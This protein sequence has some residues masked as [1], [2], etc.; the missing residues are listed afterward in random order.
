MT[1]RFEDPR[2]ALAHGGMVVFERGWL[3]SNGVLFP[4][5]PRDDAALVD[6]GYVAHQAQTEALVRHALG[7]DAP[8][9]RLI[10]THLHSDHCGGNARLQ[11]AFACRTW[12]PT[13]EFDRAQRWDT[14]HLTYEATGQRCPRF[15]VHDSLEPGEHVELG[16]RPWE[17]I[18]SPGHDPESV[19]LY[20]REL[21][22]VISADALWENGFGVVFPELEGVGAFDAV[23]STLDRLADLA[24]DWVIPGHGRVFGGACAAIDRARRRLDSFRSDPQKHA[25]HAAKVLVKFHLLEVRA[26]RSTALREWAGSV[27]YLRLMRDLYF[28]Q[29]LFAAWFETVLSDL[30]RS[31]AIRRDIEYVYDA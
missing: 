30:L 28:S 5:G 24:I 6:S 17:I 16:G 2:E 7:G 10:N 19:V 3:S 14:E 22:T 21:R 29:Q 13:G 4:G 23:G 25:L 11:A 18:A 31:G 12:V 26:E 27:P 20:Q 15:V 9:R 8:L 1:H